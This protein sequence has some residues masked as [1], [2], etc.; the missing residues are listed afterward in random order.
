MFM[1]SASASSWEPAPPALPGQS[2]A[3]VQAAQNLV[4]DLPAGALPEEGELE[5]ATEY[6]QIRPSLLHS[7]E[8]DHDSH[9]HIRDDCSFHGPCQVIVHEMTGE[10][11][12][13]EQTSEEYQW[14]LGF[15][16]ERGF[17]KRGDKKM[18]VNSLFKTRYWN[19]MRHGED[20]VMQKLEAPAPGANIARELFWL[21]E[22]Q[23]ATVPDGV[24][25]KSTLCTQPC[26]LPRCL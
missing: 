19:D 22:W 6:G 23:K 18:W 10:V 14:R 3:V 16:A 1:T 4:Q 20:F 5:E 26:Q 13:L 25:G 8:I 17:V 9:V 11:V 2:L 24:H 21:S 7:N 12:H 15:S